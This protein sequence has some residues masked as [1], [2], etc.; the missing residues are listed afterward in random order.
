MQKGRPTLGRTGNA[1]PDG[2]RNADLGRD[3]AVRK[4]PEAE[5]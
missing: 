3:F 2:L 4:G 5:K 1:Q